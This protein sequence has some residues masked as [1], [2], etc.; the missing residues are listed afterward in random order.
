MLQ[1][2]HVTNIMGALHCTGNFAVNNFAFI[3]QFAHEKTTVVHLKT[4]TF[5]EKNRSVALKV[6]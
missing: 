6:G 4:I 1:K 2:R 5:C 3:L